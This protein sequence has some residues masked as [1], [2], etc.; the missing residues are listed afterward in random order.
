M[1]TEQQNLVETLK[2]SAINK[3][4]GVLV[5]IYAVNPQFTGHL[6]FNFVNGKVMDVLESKKKRFGD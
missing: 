1:I 6:E 2:E 3:I 4:V 5:D